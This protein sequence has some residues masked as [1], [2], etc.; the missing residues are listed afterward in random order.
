MQATRELLDDFMQKV[1]VHYLSSPPL[2]Q[3][4]EVSPGLDIDNLRP[5]LNLSWHTHADE[6]VRIE[7]EGVWADVPGAAL[8]FVLQ[9][10]TSLRFLYSMTLRSDQVETLPG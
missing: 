5:M 4:L 6:P 1:L 9:E 8:K 2:L 3:F 10:T 7:T